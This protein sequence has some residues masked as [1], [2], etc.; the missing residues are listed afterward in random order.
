MKPKNGA[1]A[2]Q[3]NCARRGESM[4]ITSK[5]Q[6]GCGQRSALA[7]DFGP[8]APQRYY[9]FGLCLRVGTP[10]FHARIPA[11][12]ALRQAARAFVRADGVAGGVFFRRLRL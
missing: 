4:V 11:G 10:G 6:R 2:V 7:R 8:S 3:S 1:E 12:L 9:F 5:A